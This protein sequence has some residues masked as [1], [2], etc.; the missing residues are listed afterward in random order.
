MSPSAHGTDRS[1]AWPERWPV[2][3]PALGALIAS[4]GAAIALAEG[5]GIAGTLFASLAMTMVLVGARNYR[6]DGTDS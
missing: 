1:P 3:G 4:I 5:D 6:A 2:I